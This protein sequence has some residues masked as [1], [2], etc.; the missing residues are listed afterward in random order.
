MR[1]NY[2]DLLM[3]IKLRSYCRL[4]T[5]ALRA[6]AAAALT[7]ATSKALCRDN[8]VLVTW[9]AVASVF[10][11]FFFSNAQACGDRQLEDCQS[12]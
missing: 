2:G 8:A 10:F 6:A 7:D 4:K 11:L 12:Q 5:A 9:T 1:H 3:W